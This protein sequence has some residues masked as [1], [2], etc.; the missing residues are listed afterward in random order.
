MSQPATMPHNASFVPPP[1]PALNGGLYT[2]KTWPKGAPWRNFPVT[3]DSGFYSFTNLNNVPTAQN[4][5]LY[6]MPGNNQ[7]PRPGENTPII[8][9]VYAKNRLPNYNM[10]IVPDAPDFSFCGDSKATSIYNA[11]V[12][13]GNKGFSGLVLL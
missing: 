9:S 8:P 1:P 13:C 4:A 5:A 11:P 6:T 12:E 2:G 7:Y 3:P 10:V